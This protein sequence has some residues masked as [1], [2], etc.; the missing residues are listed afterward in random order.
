MRPSKARAAGPMV[1]LRTQRREILPR[2]TTQAHY[3]RA[4]LNNELTVGTGPAGTGKT[5]LAVAAALKLL[6][7]L[8]QNQFGTA[9]RLLGAGQENLIATIGDGNI[10]CLL[11]PN[12]IAAMFSV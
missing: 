11:Y 8:P 10:Q 9:T 5:Y 4:L 12:Q 3:I 1:A 7:K 2:S 6:V